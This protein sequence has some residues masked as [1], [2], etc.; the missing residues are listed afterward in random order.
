MK[1]GDA[2]GYPKAGQTL[3]MVVSKAAGIKNPSEAGSHSVGFSI[4]GGTE[5]RADE[6]GTKLDDLK[7]EAKISLSADDG[8]RGKEVTITGTGFNN[9]T[10][11]EAFVLVADTKPVDE[12]GKDAA[13]HSSLT[14]NSESLG[15]AAVGS[16]DEFS[17]VFTV[18]QDEF[19]PGRVNYICAKDSESEGGNRYSSDVDDPSRSRT[20]CPLPPED[21]PQAKKSPSRPRDF[22]KPRCQDLENRVP[23]RHRR[24]GKYADCAVR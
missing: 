14:S 13:R 20:R 4:I 17:I 21:E 19:D 18:H 1:D 6:A 3:I 16:D 11:A 2:T 10:T 23:G 24:R 22:A 9:G 12:D 5:D 15:T 7:T 8:G